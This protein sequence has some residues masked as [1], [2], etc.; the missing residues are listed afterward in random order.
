MRGTPR[1]PVL[2]VNPK[3]DDE[4]AF[5]RPVEDRAKHVKEW[6]R[7]KNRRKSFQNNSVGRTRRHRARAC[8]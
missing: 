8:A 6:T 5:D 3:P 7:P 2:F 4:A 1:I